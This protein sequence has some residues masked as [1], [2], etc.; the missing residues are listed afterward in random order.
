MAS[1]ALILLA[2]AALL[3]AC[4]ESGPTAGVIIKKIHEP[5]HRYTLFLPIKTSEIC[6]TYRSGTSTFRNCTPIY[7]QFP[8]IITDDED[9]V[10]ELEDDAGKHGKV[11]VSQ[12]TWDSEQVGDYWDKDGLSDQNQKEKKNATSR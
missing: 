5:E 9:W 3:A 10:L 4:G 1:K 6:S 2:V 11:K 7:T 8:Y 12:E